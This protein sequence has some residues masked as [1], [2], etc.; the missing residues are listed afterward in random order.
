MQLKFENLS[1]KE[2]ERIVMGTHKRAR[3]Q[4]PHKIE[5]ATNKIDYCSNASMLARVRG[6]RKF[7]VLSTAN[8][9]I[10]ERTAHVTAWKRFNNIK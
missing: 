7:I 6:Y 9:M 4:K 1:S 2:I 5:F 8:Q 10:M 3:S